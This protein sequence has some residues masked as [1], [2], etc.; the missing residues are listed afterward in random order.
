MF[1]GVLGTPTNEQAI[2]WFFDNV[3]PPVLK[4]NPDAIVHIAGRQ[5]SKRLITKI[6]NS[7]NAI[8]HGEL[9]DI[10]P[11]LEANSI[12]IIPVQAAAGMQNKILTAA[13]MSQ[14]I[15]AT[16]VSNEGM[17]FKH[18]KEIL[19]CQNTEDFIE[20]VNVLL[21]N[22]GEKIIADLGNAARLKVERYWT[23]NIF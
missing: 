21:G 20:S 4:D 17:D 7:P 9:D 16:K 11:L 10:R 14:A 6:R 8:F 13:A 22:T 2:T 19:V 5:A 18:K 3:W 1:C 15:I 12:S 23:W